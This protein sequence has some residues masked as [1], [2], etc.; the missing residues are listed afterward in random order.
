M[1]ADLD[2][3]ATSK[4]HFITAWPVLVTTVVQFAGCLMGALPMA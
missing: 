1:M 2:M 4:P 3:S